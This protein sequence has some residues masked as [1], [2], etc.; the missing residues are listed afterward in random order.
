M[1]IF[2]R[3]V[4]PRSRSQNQICARRLSGVRK[5]GSTF[6][7]RD[8]GRTSCAKIRIRAYLGPAPKPTCL[9]QLPCNHRSSA[10]AT[11]RPYKVQR[12][13]SHWG[14]GGSLMLPLFLAT[15]GVCV[16]Y[17]LRHSAPRCVGGFAPDAAR[18]ATPQNQDAQTPN[19]A[20]KSGNIREP[21]EPR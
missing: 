4:R 7:D 15:F 2:V 5:S 18:C 16:P 6:W 21:P 10:R 13:G 8:K 1:R 3:K 20:K 11:N 12:L 17:F 9:K 19:V 14:S